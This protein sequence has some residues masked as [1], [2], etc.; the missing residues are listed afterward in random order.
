MVDLHGQ[1]LKIKSEIDQSIQN[2]INDSTFINGSYVK[3]FERSLANYLDVKEVITCGNGT[4]ALQL[5]L[6]GLD[7]QPGDEVIVPA[8]TFVAPAETVALLNLTPVFADV[9]ELTFNITAST[10]ESLITPKT[11]AIIVVHLFGQCADILPIMELAKKHSLFVIE[12]VAQSLG[13][14]YQTGDSQKYAGTVGHIG[15]TSFFPTKNLA[16]FGDGGALMLNDQQLAAKIRML[17]NHGQPKKYEYE[18]IGLNSR[19]DAMQ[20]SILLVKLKKLD[21]YIQARK[22]IAQSY[23]RGLKKINWIKVPDYLSEDGHTFNQYTILLDEKIERK[24][25]VEYLKNKGIPTMIYYQSLIQDQPAYQKYK[26]SVLP[27]GEKLT[28]SILSLPMHTELD[29]EQ[30]DYIC[31]TLAAYT[32]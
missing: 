1:Y 18:F 13:A 7:L 17:A 2:V 29:E 10:I 11:K 28:K 15:C 27:V 3:N 14:K 22:R 23:T 4:D 16:C 21:H 6:M 30:L 20:A 19:L 32:Q 8:F 24:L 9:D 25:L 31:S 26:N 12:D 5:A